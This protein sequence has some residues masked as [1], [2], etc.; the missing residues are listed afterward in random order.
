[1]CLIKNT[2]G[3]DRQGKDIEKREG[4]EAQAV[5]GIIMENN[6]DILACITAVL[7]KRQHICTVCKYRYTL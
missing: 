5:D 2:V 1:M 7:K 6:E 3:G 4:E